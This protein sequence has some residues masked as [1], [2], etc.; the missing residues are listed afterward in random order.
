MIELLYSGNTFVFLQ[1]NGPRDLKARVLPHRFS[2]IRSVHIHY[3]VLELAYA[4][5]HYN[6]HRADRK[7]IRDLLWS[8]NTMQPIENLS[9]FIQGPVQRAW[10]CKSIFYDIGPYY[11]CLETGSLTVRMP[12]PV[13]DDNSNGSEAEGF[14]EAFAESPIRV[15]FPPRKMNAEGAD[16]DMGYDFGW[17][18]GAMFLPSLD[19]P[20]E[21]EITSYAV[22]TPLPVVH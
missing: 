20:G 19:E 14:S 21:I 7:R 10:M 4:S 12:W 9:I 22:F 15:L 13:L 6:G 18:V 17:R 11:Y 8:L 5:T 3:Q 16:L 2:A 1:N